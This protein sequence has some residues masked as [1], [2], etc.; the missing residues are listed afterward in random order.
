MNVSYIALVMDEKDNL[1]V[2]RGKGRHTQEKADAIA[3]D[4][5]LRK[6]LAKIRRS[7]KLSQTSQVLLSLSVASDGMI[8]AMHI[9]PEVQFLDVAANMNNQKRE[10]FFA[11]VKGATGQTFIV[12]ATV[13]PCGQ[14]WIFLKIYQTFFLYLYGK[15]PSNIFNLSSQ[16]TMHPLPA[17]LLT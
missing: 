12:N 3:T 17:H 7:L 16:T 10:M 14:G 4:G 8:R 11:V 6:K 9:N 15:L 2:Y 5:N 1:L 13:M